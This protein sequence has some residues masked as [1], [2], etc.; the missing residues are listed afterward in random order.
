MNY[1]N[2]ELEELNKDKNENVINPADISK[3]ARREDYANKMAGIYEEDDSYKEE[4]LDSS[5]TAYEK[6]IE[7]EY[8]E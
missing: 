3:Y 2:D 4:L 1:N 7:D 5:T 6:N 8:E